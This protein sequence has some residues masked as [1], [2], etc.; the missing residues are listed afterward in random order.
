MRGSSPFL[1]GVFHRQL[2]LTAGVALSYF[3]SERPMI[4]PEL[5]SLPQKK[6]RKTFA[7]GP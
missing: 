3:H 2:M 6:Y 7:H 4:G 5:V 1:Q